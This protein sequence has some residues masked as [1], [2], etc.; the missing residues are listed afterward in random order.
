LGADL[1]VKLKKFKLILS[2][3]GRG[4]MIGFDLP[5]DLSGVRNNLLTKHHIFTGEA[6]PNTV[7]LLPSLAIRKS[8]LD[9]FVKSLN[10]EVK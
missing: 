7:R 10:T 1:I 4:L 2:V 5:E 6:K 3:R 9:I 8:E